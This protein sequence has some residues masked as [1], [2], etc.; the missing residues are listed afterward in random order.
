M[1]LKKFYFSP[2]LVKSFLFINDILGRF[3]RFEATLKHKNTM[4]VISN[5]NL[6]FPFIP[7]T[8]HE[9]LKWEVRMTGSSCLLLLIL[10]LASLRTKIQ[11]DGRKRAR[12]S[13]LGC[14]PMLSVSV[15]QLSGPD[16]LTGEMF[17]ANSPTTT[18]LL[19]TSLK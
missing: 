10:V 1:F 9:P 2:I 11:E 6:L 13:S 4:R 14:N 16:A 5:P 3:P 8:N 18:Y 15:L 7:K 19:H 12:V 17:T